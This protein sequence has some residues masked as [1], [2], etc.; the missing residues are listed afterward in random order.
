MSHNLRWGKRAIL[1][2]ALAAW[3]C[4]AVAMAQ[5]APVASVGEQRTESA[6]GNELSVD[7]AK[8]ADRYERLEVVLARLAELSA[9]TDPRRA[10]VLREAIAKSR[11][12]GIEDRFEAI[13]ALLEGE[14]LSAATGRQSELQKELDSLLALLLKADRDR[15]LDSQ[16]KRIKA[17]LKEVSRLIRLE[18]GLQARTE[19]GDDTERLAED[20]EQVGKE[21]GKLGKS[22][23][24]T[25]TKGDE[26]SDAQESDTKSGDEEEG[27]G[28]QGKPNDGQS[29]NRRGKQGSAGKEAGKQDGKKSAGDQESNRGES[30]DAQPKDGKPS[31]GESSKGQPSKDQQGQEGQ[32][33]QQGEQGQ[34]GQPNQGQ[35]GQQGQP[36]QPGQSGESSPEQQPPQEPTDRAA[37][38]LK[39]AQRAM[40]E[41]QKKLEESERQGAALDQQEALKQL[42]QAKAELERVLRQL[43][44]EEM[45]RTLALLAARFRKMLDAQTLVWEATVRVDNIPTADRD[46]DEEIETARL[47]R[48][49]TLIAREA[50]RALVLLREE[51]SSMAFPETV[52]LMHEDML[53][54]AGRLN[55]G[56][57]A[58]RT[59][60]LERD[61]IESLEEMIAA[62][63]KAIKDLEK[64][65]TPPGQQPPAGQ[66]GDR[67]LVDKIAELKMIRALQMRINRRTLRYD[68]LMQEEPAEAPKLRDDLLELSERQQRVYQAT[69]D[70]A[71]G[72]ND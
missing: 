30:K 9:S 56:Q 72:V 39:R 31:E 46:H 35:Q 2:T 25:K 64:K 45:E 14:R 8:L 61:I 37:E 65:K 20:Q 41:A 34:P 19:G 54:V 42:E 16:R 18:K 40:Q 7:Q 47:S 62:L 36:G 5:D 66:Q 23:G 13:V 27:D 11:E 50:E 3:G 55:K 26:K 21:T 69:H 48:E 24:D 44:E 22:I 4:G 38:R 1:F 43:R 52:S 57:V 33:G 60:G 58:E 67:P 70:L 71:Q 51:G 63:D 6:P 53:E 10:K 28:K 29:S 17:Y 32:Q 12:E 59:Q 49:E 15:E 68:Q